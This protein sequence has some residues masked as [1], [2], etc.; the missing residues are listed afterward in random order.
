MV[1][2]QPRKKGWEGSGPHLV[3]GVLR[4]SSEG[5]VSNDGSVVRRA[6]R[7]LRGWWSAVG[8]VCMPLVVDENRALKSP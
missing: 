8:R 7:A 4:F 5:S 1:E 6:G 2:I 3:H